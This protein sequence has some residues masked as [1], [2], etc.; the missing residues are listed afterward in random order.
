MSEHKVTFE[1]KTTP[2]DFLIEMM[3]KV[4]EEIRNFYRHQFLTPDIVYLDWY[5]YKK[6][7]LANMKVYD[8]RCGYREFGEY[9]K[10]TIMGL[11]V[12]CMPVNGDFFE[13]AYEDDDKNI[14][15]MMYKNSL[16]ERSK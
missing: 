13:L 3:N 1:F 6:F 8:Y 2:S 12:K 4:D 14:G 5:T 9:N 15:L 10:W 11:K 16:E 7:Q